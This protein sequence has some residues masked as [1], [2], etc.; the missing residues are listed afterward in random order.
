MY[1]SKDLPPQQSDKN[2]IKPFRLK[3]NKNLMVLWCF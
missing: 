3:P 1:L 2:V